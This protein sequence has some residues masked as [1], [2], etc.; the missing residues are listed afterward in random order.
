MAIAALDKELSDLRKVPVW[1]ETNVMEY[2]DAV[3]QYP[4][5]HF[6]RLFS[7]MASRT[8][9]R[10]THHAICTRLRV[11]FGGDDVWTAAGF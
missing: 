11:V 1:E 7:I 3:V 10:P 8:Q 6:A 4:S 5:A 2:G 9:K